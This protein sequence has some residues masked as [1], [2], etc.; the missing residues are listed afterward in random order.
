MNTEAQLRKIIRNQKKIID[1]MRILKDR[2]E[3]K[4][5]IIN[6]REA[7]EI[8]RCDYQTFV[9]QFSKDIPSKKIGRRLF[10]EKGDI[11][12][13]RDGKPFPSL[14]KNKQCT[15]TPQPSRASN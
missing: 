8:L 14:N 6:T 11:Y 15:T 1:D 9:R 5:R 13:F 7:A 4:E 3:E 12:A 10:F 2:L